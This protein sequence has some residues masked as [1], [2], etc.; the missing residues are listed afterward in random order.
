VDHANQNE[1]VRQEV[2]VV[3]MITAFDEIKA[4]KMKQKKRRHYDMIVDLFV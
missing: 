3:Q 4:T 2:E 1:V